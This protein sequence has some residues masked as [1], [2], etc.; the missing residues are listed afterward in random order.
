MN[1][2]PIPYVEGQSE[3][4]CLL[5]PFGEFPGKLALADGKT[6]DV[7]QVC[8]NK[9]FDQVIANFNKEVLV[10]FEHRS[11]V[12]KIDNDTSAAGWI[13][14][15]RIGPN[16]L[17]CR[18]K[19]TD[20]G[21]EDLRNRR[22]RFLSPVWPLDAECRPLRL[23]SAALTNTPN[24]NGQPVLNKESPATTA[25]QPQE[26]NPAM[27]LKTIALALGL[28]ETATAEEVLAAVKG[29]Q[30][31]KSRITELE[32]A[33]LGAEADG[34]CAANKER[35]GDLPKFRE[36]YVANKAFALQALDAMP[37]P[38]V[39]NKA[40]GQK[41]EAATSGVVANKDSER[42]TA[43]EAIR[44][45]RRCSFVDAEAAAQARNPELFA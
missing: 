23:K 10:D 2:Q 42:R 5:C 37:K 12:R 27:D 19:L 7:L 9:A 32:K 18:N 1:T 13:Q 16:G 35:I 8:D 15:L 36:L 28:P 17:E 20:L 24:I 25:G 14:E 21:A 43:I 34:V 26:R 3:I 33:Q 41:P 30:E 40:A 31:M 44:T 38:T 11:E 39:C 4:W 22:R 6:Q 29:V 45:E